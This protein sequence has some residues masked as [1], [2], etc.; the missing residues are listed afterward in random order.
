MANKLDL[1]G[2][3]AI[4]KE[5]GEAFAADYTLDYAECS[6]VSLK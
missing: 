5:Q 2:Q 6:V 3:R 4:S 1:E